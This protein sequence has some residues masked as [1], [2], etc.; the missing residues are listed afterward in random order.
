MMGMGR[1]KQYMSSNPLVATFG[2]RLWRFPLKRS[3]P[4]FDDCL[5]RR[6]AAQPPR[7]HVVLV[8]MNHLGSF[9]PGNLLDFANPQSPALSTLGV[10]RPRGDSESP[11]GS[12]STSSR[13]GAR[14]RRPAGRAGV[15]L[16]LPGRGTPRT[17]RA[18]SRARRALRCSDDGRPSE[19]LRAQA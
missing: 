12:T 13:E 5:A 15:D 2:T 16:E 14:D 9:A 8:V 1:S 7:W 6:A 18:A 10:D 11:L 19:S 4:P 3:S 17:P